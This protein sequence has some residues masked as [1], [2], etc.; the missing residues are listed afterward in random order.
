MTVNVGLGTGNKDRQ[1]QSIMQVLEVQKELIPLGRGITEDNIYNS[2]EKL[3]EFAGLGD[4][5]QYFTDPSTQPP[6]QPEGPSPEEQVAQAQI[7]LA[8]AQAQA[9]QQEAQTNQ[10]EAVWKHEEKM[11]ELQEKDF[12]ERAKLELEYQKDI[13]GGINAA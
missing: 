8:Q 1:M 6:P 10:Q 4:V 9:V 2:L 3:V 5:N 11:K 7:Q 12:R 13:R